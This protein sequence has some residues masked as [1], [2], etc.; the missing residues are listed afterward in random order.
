[1]DGAIFYA[2]RYGS[3]A[4]YARWIS[5]ACRL[6]AFDAFNT[7]ADPA[8]YDFLVVGSAVIYHRLPIG[9]WVER[10]HER[11]RD[12]PLI[13]FTVS[14]APPGPQLDR[15]IADSLPAD[16]VARARHVPL[17]GRQDPKELGWRDRLM[18]I[19]GGLKNPDPVA[20][21]E[22]LHGFDYMDRS[23]IDAVVTLVER[24][25]HPEAPPVLRVVHG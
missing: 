6:P 9:R 23:S 1:M 2:S 12:I 20:S 24:L 18:L 3:T 8:R 10:Q 21:R 14:G 13:L 7:D 15:W 25:R 17:R 19:V 16:V 4:R 22:E 11:I 5:E